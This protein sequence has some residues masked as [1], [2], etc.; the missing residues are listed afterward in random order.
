MKIE[1]KFNK[2]DFVVFMHKSRLFARKI[3]SIKYLD[4]RIIY[5]VDLYAPDGDS[6]YV[7]KNEDECFSNLEEFVKYHRPI[8]QKQME[9]KCGQ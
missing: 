3:K 7:Q 2:G 6:V 5:S 9:R 1:T 8:L 4:E